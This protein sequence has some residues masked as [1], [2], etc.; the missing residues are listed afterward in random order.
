MTERP[1]ALDSADS[2][3]SS[4]L[5]QQIPSVIQTGLRSV[6]R[7][8]ASRMRLLSLSTRLGIVIIAGYV[9]AAILGSALSPQS[10]LR[11]QPEQMLRPPSLAHPFGTDQYGRDILSRVLV[12]TESILVLA[13]TSTLLGLLA[14][15]YLGLIAGHFGGRPGEIL[16]R[17]MDVLMALPT[18]LLALLILTTLG[19]STRNVVIGIAVVFV[20]RVARVVRS[21]VLTVR[22]SG[23]VE[24]ARLRGESSVYI[25]LVEIFPVI[26]EIVAVEACLRFSYAIL[27]GASLGFLGLGVQPPTPD[28]GLMISE[29]RNF[30]A[31][32]PWTVV[33]PAL[34]IA[35]LVIAVNLVNDGLWR[36]RRQGAIRG[37]GE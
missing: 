2:A 21:G 14:G 32:A 12:G 24:A 27:L 8:L 37:L 13:G 20:P 3:V 10:A 26:R 33:F 17:A 19:P 35:S 5:R 15:T 9:L 22:D 4:G 7:N 34:A 25:M 1:E 11:F 16:M 31:Y 30:I 29:G 36:A 23:F 6:L 28:W 18:M